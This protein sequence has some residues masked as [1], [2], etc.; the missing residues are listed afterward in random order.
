MSAENQQLFKQMAASY[1]FEPQAVPTTF[2]A[3]R[4]WVGFS[5]DRRG[6]HRFTTA[7]ACLDRTCPDA[8]AAL[9]PAAS[10][11]AGPSPVPTTTSSPSVVIPLW[12]EVSLTGQSL[13]VSTAIIGFIDGFNPCSLWVLSIL[14]A[15]TL[16]TGSRRRILL[17]G[18]IFLVLTAAVYALFILE[19]FFNLSSRHTLINIIIMF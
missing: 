1:G 17:V 14:I 15:L 8:G 7:V 16:H 2:V 12:G 9:I 18:G 6:R 3:D 4:Y 5:E 19:L 11:A 13:L 10:A